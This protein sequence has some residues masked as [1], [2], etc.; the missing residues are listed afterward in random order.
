MTKPFQCTQCGQCCHDLNI[1]LTAKESID[2]I[3]GGNQVKVL[4]EAI[5]WSEETLQVNE[6]LNR[7]KQITF[8]SL[9]GSLSIRVQVTFL[10]YFLGACPNLDAQLNCRRQPGQF[11]KSHCKFQSLTQ[12]PINTYK[13]YSHKIPPI[14]LSKSFFVYR[15]GSAQLHCPMTGIFSIMSI[16]M[17]F[18]H[19]Y[20]PC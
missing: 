3:S 2:W 6:L 9:S 19:S 8:A 12:K 11:T 16:K 17:N 18:A 10:G 7:K 4:V 5:P 14:W 1:P 20:S 13:P 15:S